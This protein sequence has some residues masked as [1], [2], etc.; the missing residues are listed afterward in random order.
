MLNITPE[1][2]RQAYLD[3]KLKPVQGSFGVH[4][5]ADHI[6]EVKPDHDGRCCA[7]GA[8]LVGETCPD[9]LG[10]SGDYM[11]RFAALAEL[12]FDMTPEQFGAFWSGFDRLN[13]PP[14]TETD[15]YKLGA[16]CWEAV[17][18]LAASDQPIEIKGDIV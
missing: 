4:V 5:N 10:S 2:V 7:I 1:A 3:K 13:D 8:M 14:V 12:F 11:P 15:A 6:I 9:E 16:A 18:D 17:K